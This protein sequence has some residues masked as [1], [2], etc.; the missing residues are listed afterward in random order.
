MC[1]VAE[2]PAISRPSSTQVGWCKSMS[3]WAAYE[4]AHPGAAERL[5]ADLQ[6]ALG[7]DAATPVPMVWPLTMLLAKQ[8]RPLR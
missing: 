2:Q 4:A 6:A 7:V 1:S 8:P 3:G 5:A